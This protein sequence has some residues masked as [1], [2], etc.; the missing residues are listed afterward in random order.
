[1]SVPVRYPWHRY[2]VAFN[3]L[4]RPLLIAFAVAVKGIFDFLD[5]DRH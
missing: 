3:Y 1:M 5:H 2:R 4:L